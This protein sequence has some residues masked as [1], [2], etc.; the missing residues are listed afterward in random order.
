MPPIASVVNP[1]DLTP[2]MFQPERLARFAK[3]LEVIAD[4]PNIDIVCELMGGTGAGSHG[5][6]SD[7]VTDMRTQY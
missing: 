4:D 5:R 6:P 2:D 7:V 1:I 3:A